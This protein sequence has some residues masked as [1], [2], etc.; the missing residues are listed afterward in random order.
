MYI[1]R[2]T[3]KNTETFELIINDLGIYT[4]TYYF[5]NTE[6]SQLIQIAYLSLVIC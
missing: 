6:A 3:Y 1:Y 5:V 2:P 4:G